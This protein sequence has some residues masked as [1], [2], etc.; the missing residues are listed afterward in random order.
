MEVIFRESFYGMNSYGRFMDVQAY[1]GW[2]YGL[3]P[4]TTL[5]Q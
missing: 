3:H 2:F 1:Y 5:I 4:I